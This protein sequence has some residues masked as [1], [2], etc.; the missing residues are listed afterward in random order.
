M[1][2][3]RGACAHA[4][5]VVMVM[6]I[7]WPEQ[8]VR[9]GASQICRNGTLMLLKCEPLTRRRKTNRHV[10]GEVITRTPEAPR[11]HRVTNRRESNTVA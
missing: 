1:R 9:V 8:Y 7:A 10:V 2:E 3:T 4:A 6:R 11:R 5:E